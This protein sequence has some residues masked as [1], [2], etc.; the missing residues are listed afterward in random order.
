MPSSRGIKGVV[1]RGIG[2]D[3]GVDRGVATGDAIRLRVVGLM[4]PL[5]A[6]TGLRLG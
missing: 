4:T 5:I 6:L 1:Q 3:L 2:V